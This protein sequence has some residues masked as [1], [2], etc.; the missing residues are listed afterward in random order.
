MPDIVSMIKAMKLTWVNSL[1]KYEHN[2]KVVSQVVTGISDFQTFF[3]KKLDL[4]HIQN[5]IPLFYKQL[6]EYWFDFHGTEP[7]DINEILNESLW[8][9]KRILV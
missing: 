6:F 2:F 1:L 7:R 3:M 8:Q 9:N 4:G 5:G